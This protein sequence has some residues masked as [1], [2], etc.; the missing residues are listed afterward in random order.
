LDFKVKKRKESLWLK[1]HV[2]F[3]H[4]RKGLMDRIWLGTWQGSHASQLNIEGKGLQIG[5]W[6]KFGRKGILLTQT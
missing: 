2:P 5:L 6:L 1:G 4:R 3:G